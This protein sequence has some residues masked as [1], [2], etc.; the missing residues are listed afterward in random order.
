MIKEYSIFSLYNAVLEKTYF[1]PIKTAA[2]NTENTARLLTLRYDLP[3]SKTSL[4]LVLEIDIRVFP[5]IIDL[6][7]KKYPTLT[8]IPTK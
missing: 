2:R 6:N 5:E 8:T 3:N 1:P 4:I 7:F